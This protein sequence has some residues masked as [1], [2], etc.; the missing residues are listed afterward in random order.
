[1]E[2]SQSTLSIIAIAAA[3]IAVLALLLVFL[4]G[5]RLRR[6]R[7]FRPRPARQPTDPGVTTP[8]GPSVWDETAI[9]Y[10]LGELRDGLTHAVQRVGL[11]RFDAFEDMGGQ[12]SFAAALLD[13]DGSGIVL[14]SINGR[15]ETRIYAKPIERGGSAYNLSQE[16]LEA[17]RRALGA[18]RR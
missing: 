10:E 16:E 8:P 12:Q 14:S 13:A 5:R 9:A 2:L 1:M 18:V 17:V 7:R 11:V 3:G 4:L 6:L 15:A